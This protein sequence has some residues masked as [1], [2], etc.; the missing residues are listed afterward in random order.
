MS[1]GQILFPEE[2]QTIPLSG[3]PGASSTTSESLCRYDNVERKKAGVDGDWDKAYVLNQFPKNT[4]HKA[5]EVQNAYWAILGQAG[6]NDVAQEAKAFQEYKERVQ[7]AGGFKGSYKFDLGT[8]SF[9]QKADQIIVGPLSIKYERGFAKI[10]N[11]EKVNFGG[12]KDIKIFDQNGKEVDKNIWKITYDAEHKDTKKERL[13]GDED[14]G[15]TGSE[16]YSYPYSG[17]AFNIVLDASKCKEKKITKISKVQVILYDLDIMADYQDISGVYREADWRVESDTYTCTNQEKFTDMDG[18]EIVYPCEHGYT[19]SH[20]QTENFRLVAHVRD[21]EPQPI[22]VVIKTE[23]TPREGIIE[24]TPKKD[25]TT[26]T[27]TTNKGI[28]SIIKVT[29]NTPSTPSTPNWPEWPD[30]PDWPDDDDDDDDDNDNPDD[31]DNDNPDDNDDDNPDDDNP[32]DNDN[33]NPDDDNPGDNDNDNP[34]DDNPGD[35]DDGGNKTPPDEPDLSLTIRL[36]GVVWE[37]SQTG[38][39]S[40][41]DGVIGY[42]NDGT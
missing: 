21:L 13:A 32:G 24:I 38:K 20:Q 33:D 42:Q 35:D 14:Y 1:L 25:S 5:G 40:E 26:I 37:D 18:N 2:G 9:D 28:P 16:F 12:I 41:Y 4:D 34:D 36:S 19:S 6:M 27:T 11:R 39:E 23:E 17:E 29:T 3:D 7:K 31:N 10:G 15:A 22:S 8:V 30:Y